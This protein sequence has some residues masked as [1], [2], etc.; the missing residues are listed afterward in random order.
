MNK[1]DESAPYLTKL[2]TD[3][4]KSKFVK[5]AQE[6]LKEIEARAKVPK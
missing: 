3:H 6:R 1:A 2:I 5:K 4:P